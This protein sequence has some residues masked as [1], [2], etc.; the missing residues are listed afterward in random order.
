MIKVD[1]LARTYGTLTAV[2]DAARRLA[3]HT[4]PGGRKPRADAMNPQCRALPR[5]W[6]GV[7]HRAGGPGWAYRSGPRVDNYVDRCAGGHPHRAEAG[8]GEDLGE[9]RGASLVPK[10]EPAVLG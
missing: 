5:P 4:G 9:S 7:D 2:H 3:Q 1:H 6:A 10:T 8:R